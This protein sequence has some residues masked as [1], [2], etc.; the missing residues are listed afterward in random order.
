MRTAVWSGALAAFLGLASS[1]YWARGAAPEDTA[2]NAWIS[3]QHEV[4]AALKES[5][6]RPHPFVKMSIT[7]D[8]K[9]SFFG[10]VPHQDEALRSHVGQGW[11]GTSVRH[12]QMLLD[13]DRNA[14]PDGDQGNSEKMVATVLLNHFFGPLEKLGYRTSGSGFAAVSALQKTSN[15]WYRI[16]RIG[17]FEGN[18]EG[19]GVE[20]EVVVSLQDG[21]AIIVGTIRTRYIDE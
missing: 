11:R 3:R 1:P 7:E 16:K 21:Q 17:P 12:F 2:I 19:V 6:S 9:S 4:L 10:V 20:G 5:F 18:D 8:D 14:I 15:E 13:L